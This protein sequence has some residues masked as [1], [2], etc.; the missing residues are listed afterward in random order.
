MGASGRVGGALARALDGRVPLRR[1]GRGAGMTKFDL[2]DPRTFDAALD[3]VSSVFLMRPPQ[4]A[5]GAAFRPFLEACMARGIQRMVVLSVKGADRNRVLPHN[6][7]EHEVKIRG[8]DW[9]MLRPADF[10]QNLETVHRDDIRLRDEI[11]VPAGGG[12]SAFVDVE[13]VGAAAAQVLVEDGH[14]GRGYT[15]TGPE[16]LT[17]EQVADVLSEVLGRRI[18][19]RPP[20]VPAFIRSRMAEAT[21]FGMALVMTALYS[22]QRAGGAAEVT[23]ELPRLLGHPAT[24]LRTYVARASSAWR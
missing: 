17:F 3:G 11:A 24:D 9:T 1:A 2:T 6:A 7:M 14:S 13:D 5:R 22:V 23:E 21:P 15:L 4:I 19:Y 10:M 20:S 18:R 12:A 8:F 16:A